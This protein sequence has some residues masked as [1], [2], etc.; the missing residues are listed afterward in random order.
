MLAGRNLPFLLRQVREPDNYRALLR[1]PTVVVR[2]LEFA[3]RYFLGAGPY[4]S[5][6]AVR[7]PLGTIAP[8]AYSCHDVFT[9]NEVFCRL[10]YRLPPGARV[11]VDVGSNI[12]LSALYFMTRSGDVSCRLFEPDP[13]NVRRLRENLVGYESRYRL[14]EVAVG[15]R[16]GRFRFGREITGRYGGL[17]STESE[18]VIEVACVSINDVLRTTLREEGR[19]DVLKLDTEGLERRTVEAIEPELL[20][21][22]AV[23]CFEAQEP[24]NPMPDLFEL[25]FATETVRLVNRHRA[26]S[27]EAPAVRS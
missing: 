6:I 26:T 11:V 16:A 7:T 14:S 24:I 27:S 2:P 3:R 20:R 1:M 23:V 5:R 13:R 8:T 22:V 12:G 10:D 9:I 17:L 4:P 25:H 18:D 19:I 21:Q 15:D